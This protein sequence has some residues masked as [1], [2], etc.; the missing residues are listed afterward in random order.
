MRDK[1]VV[2]SAN[3]L[4]PEA[5]EIGLV[6]GPTGVGTECRERRDRH[7]GDDRCIVLAG[8]KLGKDT[9][10][11][12]GHG[13][14]SV[15]RSV[16]Y[17]PFGGIGARKLVDRLEVSPVLVGLLLL[18]PGPPTCLV[19]ILVRLLL[20]LPGPVFL[21]GGFGVLL[22][23]HL[24]INVLSWLRFTEDD[25]VR[26]R[27]VHRPQG[28]NADAKLVVDLLFDFITILAS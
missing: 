19:L 27:L 2:L 25:G 14:V 20:L 9:G 26:L 7:S 10:I 15:L 24:I 13:L 12:G 16:R 22:R 8:G 3:V 11:P 6:L 5:E 1:E 4:L 21:L 18:L 17:G 23:L 28:S